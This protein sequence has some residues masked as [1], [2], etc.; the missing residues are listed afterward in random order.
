MIRKLTR[1]I[2]GISLIL[3]VSR[4]LKIYDGVVNMTTEYGDEYIF[5]AN[6]YANDAKRKVTIVLNKKQAK[7]LRKELKRFLQS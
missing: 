2:G 7:K 3:Q 5:V 1:L 6:Q 4:M